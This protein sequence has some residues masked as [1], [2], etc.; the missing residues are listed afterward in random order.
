MVNQ[1]SLQDNW[2]EITCKLRNKWS[3]L[4]N[5]DLQA[6]QGNIEQLVALIQRQTGEA[7][8]AIEHFLEGVSTKRSS[9]P[10]TK[11]NSI[12]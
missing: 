5:E 11:R 3:Q 2:H 12:R 8:I 6:A 4:T 10:R 9:V 7:R 1:Q